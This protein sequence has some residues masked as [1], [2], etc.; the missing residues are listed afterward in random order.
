MKCGVENISDCLHA[1]FTLHA[2]L[3]AY[4]CIRRFRFIASG[5][6]LY[7]ST[8]RIAVVRLFA[9]RLFDC[10]YRG[11]PTVRIKVV[12]I[13]LSLRNGRDIVVHSLCPFRFA[14]V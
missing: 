5:V 11:C 9:S 14:A 13:D 1:H 4:H 12:R 6:V 8:V 7:R 10:T 3:F 2:L